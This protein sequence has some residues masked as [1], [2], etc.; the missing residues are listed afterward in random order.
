MTN[1]I[2]IIPDVHGR[3]FWKYAIT[4]ID[5]YD[6]VI[7]LGDY[8][9]PY[10]YEEISFEDAVINFKEIL[11]FKKA[12]S[13][14]V[15]L[16]IGN[17]DCHYIWLDFMNCSRLNK[18]RRAEMNKL[19]NSNYKLFKTAY[20]CEN[21]LFSHAGVYNKWLENNDL[22]LEDFLDKDISFWNGKASKLEDCGYCRGGYSEVGSIVWADIRESLSS[23]LL[24]GY[25]HIVGH[26]QLEEFPYL[27]NSIACLDVRKPFV[28]DLDKKVITN[29][30]GAEYKI[31]D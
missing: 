30:N 14:K 1:K 28:V 22:K 9:D 26:T 24:D 13:D 17:H 4:N 5:K 8:L 18:S 7:F 23:S 2:L 15:E 10:P 3:T 29:I 12:N 6:K 21:Y 25:R 20:L 16:L 11:E 19:F 27:T 31:Y